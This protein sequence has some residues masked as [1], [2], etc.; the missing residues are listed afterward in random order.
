MV[1]GVTAG[2]N[3]ARGES[4]RRTAPSSASWV[5]SSGMSPSR[6]DP[7]PCGS[8]KKYKRCCLPKEAAA[9]PFLSLMPGSGGRGPRESRIAIEPG[10]PVGATW[11]VDLVPFAAAFDDEPA[12]RPA[13][14]LI[15][16]DD[17]VLAVDIVA[18]PPAEH[19]A[20]AAVIADEIE[21][22]ASALGRRPRTVETHHPDIAA[23]LEPLLRPLDIR[24][25][26]APLPGLDRA[27]ASLQKN[28]LGAEPRGRFS[29]PQ[30]WAGWGWDSDTI[31]ALFRDM[32]AYY[33]TAPWETVA[34]DEVLTLEF[35]DGRVWHAVVMGNAGETYGLALYENEE[36]LDALFAGEGERNEEAFADLAGMVLSLT[37]NRFDDL[38]PGMHREI[39]AA[40]WEVAG[41]RAH[42]VLI[43]MNT[44]GGGIT[45][46]QLHDLGVALR[47]IPAFFEAHRAAF[48]KSLVAD[49]YPAPIRWTDPASGVTVSYIGSWNIGPIKFGPMPEQLEISGTTGKGAK[50][51]ERLGKG[52]TR[53]RRENVDHERLSRYLDWLLARAGPGKAAAK[54]REA[55][56]DLAVAVD[57]FASLIAED[58]TIRGMNE[59]D[60]R[61]HLYGNYALGA[62]PNANHGKMLESLSR[63]FEFLE[64]EEGIVCPWAWPI[65]GDV[66]RVALRAETAPRKQG[67]A[68]EAEWIVEMMD[69]LGMRLLRPMD[70]RDPLAQEWDE[71]RELGRLRAWLVRRDKIIRGGERRPMVVLER[72]IEWARKEG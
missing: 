4:I 52:A 54:E 65:L 43:A 48:E 55:R 24:V 22:T 29:V 18:K 1:L 8:G 49:V 67:D 40:G 66:E 72:L 57:F 15:V 41:P 19:D 71:E 53:T 61:V 47:A 63:F 70:G 7:C 69:D 2:I 25:A 27:F 51:G 59:H 17:L 36:D 46:Q 50:H 34:D 5:A 35:G 64:A 32:A 21:R 60:L 12:A 20:I 38:P 10:A 9:S 11:Q 58:V 56:G 62:R 14:T 39:R 16:S 23:G 31:A 68:E 33:R 44:P 3:P 45:R 42:P 26:C 30:R 37:Y 13:V 6:N 28:V